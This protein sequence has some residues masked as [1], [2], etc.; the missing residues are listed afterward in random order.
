MEVFHRFVTIAGDL[1]CEVAEASV[2]ILIPNPAAG[3]R[4]ALFRQPRE[5]VHD[6]L[7]SWNLH[8]AK[9]STGQPAGGRCPLS[10][11]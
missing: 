3:K 11:G 1:S 7:L 8:R 9:S 6:A 10:A 4:S 2:A 5:M